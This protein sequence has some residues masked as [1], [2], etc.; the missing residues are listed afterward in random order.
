M[1]SRAKNGRDGAKLSG[2]SPG[3]YRW[4]TPLPP[5]NIFFDPQNRADNFLELCMRQSIFYSIAFR[6]NVAN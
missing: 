5:L 3:L 6:I 2:F 4:G 1:G